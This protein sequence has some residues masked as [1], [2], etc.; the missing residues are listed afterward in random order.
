MLC[1]TKPTQILGEL[2]AAIGMTTWSLRIADSEGMRMVRG[3][4]GKE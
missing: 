3:G 4:G 2:A 1:E